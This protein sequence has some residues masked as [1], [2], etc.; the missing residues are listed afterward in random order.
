MHA[1]LHAA[2]ESAL[3]LRAVRLGD[4][5]QARNVMAAPIGRAMPAT[6]INPV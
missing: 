2:G 5:R 4:F 1:A 3:A 6:Q